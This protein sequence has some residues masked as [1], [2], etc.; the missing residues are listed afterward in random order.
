MAWVAAVACSWAGE[1]AQAQITLDANFDSGSLCL[2]PTNACDD[3]GVASSVSGSVVNLVGRDNFDSGN[4]KWVYFRATGVDGLTPEFRIGNDFTTG[5]SNLAN[6][7]FVYSYDQHNWS[8][9]DNGQL[10]TSQSRYVFSNSG[11]FVQDEVY[12]AYGLPYPMSRVTSHTLGLASSPWVSSLP[13]GGGSL[14]IGQSPG[15]V[16]DIGRSIP[17]QPLYAYLVTDPAVSS[18]SKKQV[19]LLGG[20]HSN[21]TLANFVL[22][23]LVD[24]LTGP[25][26]RAA[27]LRRYAEFAVYPMSNPDGRVAGMNRTTV[28]NQT[29]DP[30]RVWNPATN[31]NN[32]P[33]IRTIGQSMRFEAGSVDYMVDFHSTVNRSEAPYHFAYITAANQT[34]PL[35]LNLLEREPP[36]AAETASFST[37]FT[38]ARFGFDTLGADFSITFETQFLPGENVSRFQTLGRNF[39][40]AM[41][42]T[43]FVDG[44]LD[45]DGSLDVADWLTFFA[46]AERSLGALSPLAR[47]VSGDLDGDGVNSIA[48]FVRF[49]NA[50][51]S[52]NGGGSFA[53]MLASVPEPNALALGL[54]ALSNLSFHRRPFTS[55]RTP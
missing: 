9:F 45:F 4:W 53:T 26:L 10:Q 11:P 6:H 41:W 2:V 52:A 15:G 39:G 24:F 38:G 30:N 32:Q 1:G 8:F 3:N 17:P 49:K 47:Y 36:L 13:S 37:D 34:N 55:R 16:D 14:V 33:E 5:G 35:W 31:Y 42:E 23:G 7:R 18:A 54:F 12:V 28:Q 21:E 25:D 46:G 19:V 22:E 20:T 43:L 27:Q 40:L 50:Y 44:D 51:E 29:T 48:D